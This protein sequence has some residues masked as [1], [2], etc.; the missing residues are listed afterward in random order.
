M[1][2]FNI[3]KVIICSL[4]LA[5]TAS[6]DQ[7]NIGE[8]YA[9]NNDGISF[10]AEN[11][12]I[13]APPDQTS[14][15]YKIMRGNAQGKL[16]LPIAAI[17]DRDVFTLPSSVVFEDGSGMA[18]LT[19][20]LEKTI[21]GVAYTIELAVDSAAATKFGNAKTT[22]EVTRD[23]NW[24][25]IGTGLW[26]DGLVCA[27]FSAS[28]LT[29]PVKI[30]KAA[31]AKAIF[32]MVNPYGLDEYEYNDPEDV[33]RN[34]N[35]VVINA[36]DPE[37]V[38]I[39]RTGLGIDWGYG[40]IFAGTRVGMYGTF[41]DNVITFPAG[42]IGVGMPS[43]SGEN[44]GAASK[45]CILDMRE[46][47]PSYDYS[48]KIEY[49]G[50]YTDPAED[51]YAT[52]KVTLGADV[53][54]GKVAL[55]SGGMTQAALTG[56]IDGS[57]ESEDI[58]AGGDVSLPLT[59]AGRWTFVLVTFDDADEPQDF[60][61]TSFNFVASS[62]VKYPIEDFFGDYVM[63]GF[64]AFDDTEGSMEVAIAPGEEPNTLII[65]GVD[66]AE[67]IL[68]TFPVKGY[69][70]VVPQE[71]PDFVSGGAVYDM[72]LY[73][74]TPDWEISDTDAM[75]FTRLE[76]GDLVLASD[77]YAIGCLIR[78]EKA[79]GWVDGYYDIVFTPVSSAKA[80]SMKSA[81]SPVLKSKEFQKQAKSSFIV[82]KEANKKTLKM[83][84][85]P[86]ELFR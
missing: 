84:I 38:V 78:S 61:Y 39:V 54:Y 45:I 3:Y 21:L 29:Y 2:T 65:T 15:D 74:I 13:I 50:R 82:K 64:S 14:I 28:A 60:D 10:S 26:T 17:Y 44:Y 77:T 5:V 70:S 81:A 68:A 69:M 8:E 7:E 9:I 6:C 66:Y 23:Y 53:A 41:A 1:K 71:L 25:S 86:A 79:G 56:V 47:G 80:A 11:S 73:T 62:D 67:S 27:I 30:E 40:E 36:E 75:I 20:P 46:Q 42:T 55:I 72:A 35:Y 49:T 18:T 12:T 32:R 57:V 31:E 4:L 85:K 22:I 83:Q 59:G 19:I 24:V 16:E 43:W 63:S 48:A 58:S 37:K 76:S 51:T 52:A 33:I 34:P